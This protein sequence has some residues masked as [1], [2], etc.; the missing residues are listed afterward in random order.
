MSEV[1][2]IRSPISVIGMWLTTVSAVTFLVVFLA[3]LFGLHTN[4]YIGILFFLILPSI[5][6]VGLILIPFGAWV[7]KRRRDRGLPPSA[8]SWPTINLNEPSQRRTA[9]AI[10]ALTMANIVIVS[11]ATYRGI[12]YIGLG[13]VLRPGVSRGDAPRVHGIPGRSALARDLRAVPHRTGRLVVRAIEGLRHA[14]G[15]GRGARQLLASDRLT[16]A[17]PASRTRGLRAVPLAGEVP[18]RRGPSRG[19]VPR[20]TRRTASR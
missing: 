17:E 11:L 14:A 18:R 1:R 2:L 5:F 19:R 10:F 20:T 3:D 9:V 15:A 12:E 13:P 4:P 16:G 6:I 8:I 7:E